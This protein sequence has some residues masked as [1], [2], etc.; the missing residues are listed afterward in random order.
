MAREIQTTGMRK[1][2]GSFIVDPRPLRQ[3]ASDLGF[4]EHF[5]FF[6][7]G[8]AEG[9]RLSMSSGLMLS[10]DWSRLLDKVPSGPSLCLFRVS[11]FVRSVS[12]NFVLDMFSFSLR[13]LL[14]I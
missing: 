2:A 7:F 4:L 14:L 6:L 1:K 11:F 8:A 13:G 12:L 3:W 5:F 9:S 10:K